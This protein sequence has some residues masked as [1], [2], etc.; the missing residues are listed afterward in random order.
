MFTEA[1][2][3]R[4]SEIMKD[5]APP[6]LELL[7]GHTLQKYDENW[8]LVVAYG[9]PL[10]YARKENLGDCRLRVSWNIEYDEA[11]EML[12]AVAS[13]P[14]FATQKMDVAPAVQF[15]ELARAITY[16]CE[17]GASNPILMTHEEA[18]E[19]RARFFK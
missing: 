11:R 4:V 2:Q 18:R 19:V 7:P 1:L 14:G 13:Y 8:Y 3:A 5:L 15:S 17:C 16:P 12:Y 10:A 9:K 6:D